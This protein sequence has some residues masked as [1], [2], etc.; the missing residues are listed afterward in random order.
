MRPHPTTTGTQLS[1]KGCN[2]TL[3]IKQYADDTT[4]ILKNLNSIRYVLDCVNEFGTVAGLQLNRAKSE[5][6]LLGAYKDL[7]TEHD[8]I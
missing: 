5:G 8:G 3:K 7:Y 6:I 4:L 1:I 2:T